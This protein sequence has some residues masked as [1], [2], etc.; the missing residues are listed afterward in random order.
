MDNNNS[1]WKLISAGINIK[2]FRMSTSLKKVISDECGC[3]VKTTWFTNTF[4]LIFLSN[5][6][7][8]SARDEGYSRNV[9][10]AAN[11]ISTFVLLIQIF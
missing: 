6:L 11:Y 5:H 4:K 9:P 2:V 8:V 7:T 3:H 10:C 1:Y